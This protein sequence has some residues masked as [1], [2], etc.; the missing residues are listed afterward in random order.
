MLSR[1][2]RCNEANDGCSQALLLLLLLLLL[3]PISSPLFVRIYPDVS[4]A[5]HYQS[6]TRR[7]CS[8]RPSNVLLH[9]GVAQLGPKTQLS[10]RVKPREVQ[11]RGKHCLVPSVVSPAGALWK[12]AVDI[13]A[14]LGRNSQHRTCG[15][16]A[17]HVALQEI[18]QVKQFAAFFTKRPTCMPPALI[19]R[20]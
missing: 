17:I 11:Q 13:P 8:Q 16:A 14:A 15:H 20:P 12:Q 18:Q 19:G 1:I 2:S 7:R 4:I 5:S 6:V 9:V 3:L 10:V